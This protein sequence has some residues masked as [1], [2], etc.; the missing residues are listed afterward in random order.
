MKRLAI[1]ALTLSLSAISGNSLANLSKDNFYLKGS[2]GA[3]WGKVHR[4]TLADGKYSNISTYFNTHDKSGSY[5]FALGYSNPIQN[6]PF[7]VELQTLHINRQTFKM[8]ALY[9]T[10]DNYHD[11]NNLTISSNAILINI[12]HSWVW[13]SSYKPFLGAGAGLSFNKTAANFVSD[14]DLGYSGFWPAKTRA[15]FAYDF[16]AG[17]SYRLNS[18]LDLSIIYQYFGLGKAATRD[19]VLTTEGLKTPSNFFAKQ[20]STNNII[21]AITYKF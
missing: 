13:G 5:G 2:V 21:F 4:L 14:T 17:V 12:I 6:F 18:Q 11:F 1:S 7:D 9:P 16:L 3:S 15:N 20:F 19:T 10:E 8:G